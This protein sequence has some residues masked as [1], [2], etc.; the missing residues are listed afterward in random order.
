MTSADFLSDVD[1]EDELEEISILLSSDAISHYGI[2]LSLESI[3]ID[4]GYK[5]WKYRIDPEDPRIPLQRHIHIARSKHIRTKN[6]QASWNVDGTRHD[7]KS[8]NTAVGANKRVQEIV[9]C[10]LS[11]PPEVSLESAGSLHSSV[12]LIEEITFSPNGK[13]AFV[14]FRSP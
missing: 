5:D 4:L 1:I 12:D 9:K 8:F 11:I 2:H 14:A 7:K 13:I 10:V 3:W 6:M